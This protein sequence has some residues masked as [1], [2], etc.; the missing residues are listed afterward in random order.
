MTV[1]KL[2]KAMRRKMKTKLFK[3]TKRWQDSKEMRYK[4]RVL[5]LVPIFIWVLAMIS[6]FFCTD[7]DF[8][9]TALIIVGTIGFT[10]LPICAMRGAIMVKRTYA[11]SSIADVRQKDELRLTDDYLEYSY[12]NPQYVSAGRRMAAYHNAGKWIFRIPY[13]NIKAITVFTKI[14]K[15]VIETK[16]CRIFKNVVDPEIVKGESHQGLVC[17]PLYFKNI[18]QALDCLIKYTGL[19]IQTSDTSDVPDCCYFEQQIPF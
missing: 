5:I 3:Q 15:T 1:Y 4:G 12:T 8:F 13:K 9:D 17:I 11:K 19:Q 14:N 7:Y 18:D 16:E 6:L 2:N 10:I